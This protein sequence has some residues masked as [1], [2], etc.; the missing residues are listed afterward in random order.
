MKLSVVILNYNVRY[1]LELCLR[2][3]QASLDGINSE[4]IV[5]D[6]DSTDESC[7]MVKNKFPNVRLIENKQNVGFS[8]ANNQAVLQAKGEY[9]CILNPDV[10]LT[11]NT[12][13][14]LL[15]FSESKSNVGVVGCRLIDGSGLFLPESKRNFPKISISIQ[16][17]IGIGTKYYANQ[18]AELDSKPVDVIPGALMFLRRSLYNELCGFDEDFF[19][20]GEDID[21]SLTI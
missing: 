2:S 13:K 15:N 14:N 6:N 3:V 20:Y 1:F 12:L 8:K 4:I 9:V 18:I 7:T 11:E 5:I 17:F 10:V 19:M 21:L 16:K